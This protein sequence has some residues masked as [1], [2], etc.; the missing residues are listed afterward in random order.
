MLETSILFKGKALLREADAAYDLK[1]GRWVIDTFVTL[2]PQAKPGLY[3]LQL[4][5]RGKRVRFQRTLSFTV[6]A[7]SGT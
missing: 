7:V 4:K 6:R 2:P 3:G 1:P 5:F